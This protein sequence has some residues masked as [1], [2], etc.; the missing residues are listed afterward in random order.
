MPKRCYSGTCAHLNRL[1]RTAAWV[2]VLVRILFA[3]SAAGMLTCAQQPVTREPLQTRTAQAAAAARRALCVGIA[4]PRVTAAPVWQKMSRK[5]SRH[6]VGITPGSAGSASP[7]T[8]LSVKELLSSPMPELAS[9]SRAEGPGVV[10]G[11]FSSPRLFSG[12]VNWADSVP[13][14]SG[15][16]LLPSTA[17]VL[18]SRQ[19]Q[20]ANPSILSQIWL[21][22]PFTWR[23]T[24]APV[25]VMETSVRA[26]P[27]AAV[28]L[29]SVS[30][31]TNALFNP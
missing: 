8:V 29:G 31:F 1:L 16:Q 3:G 4:A 9:V 6:G 19:E 21:W 2:C 26:C 28:C 18:L 20:R 15:R 5:K 7:G 10:R 11:A 13:P 12:E 25:E 23:Q 17:K 22:P 24:S 27:L 14:E 30:Y